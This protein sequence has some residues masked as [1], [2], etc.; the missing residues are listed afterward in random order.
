MTIMAMVGLSACVELPA[1]PHDA[2][3]QRLDLDPAGTWW[4][5]LEVEEP[6]R[7]A[8][9]VEPGEVTGTWRVD[10]RFPDGNREDRVAPARRIPGGLRVVGH[11]WQVELWFTSP[12]T[13][14]ANWVQGGRWPFEL[15]LGEPVPERRRPQDPESPVPYETLDVEVPGEGV[16]LG[17]T[18]TRPRG[19]ER[20]P[21]LVFVSGSGPDNRDARYSGHRPFL[22]LAD[23]LVRRG[24]ASLRCDERGVRGSSGDHASAGFVELA[25]DVQAGVGWLRA[26]PDVA[27]VGVLGHSDG[28]SLVLLVDADL[29][30]M[31]AGSPGATLETLVD[32]YRTLR[33]R[34]GA[35]AG[36][37]EEG[38]RALQAVYEAVRRDPTDR[39]TLEQ[40]IRALPGAADAE[41]AAIR[42]EV[43]AMLAPQ[44]VARLRL[45]GRALLQARRR[46]T[47]AVWGSVDPLV[48]PDI[49]RP[50][51]VEATAGCPACRSLV[52][53]DVNHMLQPSSTGDPDEY[54]TND[55]TIAPAVVDAV[56]SWVLAQVR[57][58]GG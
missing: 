58:S 51:F 55:V 34:Q 54:A 30:V 47:L 8:F 18:F 24:I 17:C 42:G 31:L 6:I 45:D 53:P 48:R 57:R 7:M 23:Q 13:A 46:P 50:A 3:T 35:S 2:P 20:V 14:D 5:E 11:A 26:R 38:A 22:V 28:A 39:E 1:P 27:T 4:G 43:E 41:E 44:M 56:S 12:R 37:A 9:G 25:S 33:R 19:A 36:Q 21:A 52:L 15:T 10:L 29:A 49:A 16:Q 40:R 32:Q